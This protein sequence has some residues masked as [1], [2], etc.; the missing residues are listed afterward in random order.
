MKF[1][2]DA[3]IWNY[4]QVLPLLFVSLSFGSKETG[5]EAAAIEVKK[6]LEAVQE[7]KDC[8]DRFTF[9]KDTIINLFH[10]R[11]K[12]PNREVIC[13]AFLSEVLLAF[14]HATPCTDFFRSYINGNF[15]SDTEFEKEVLFMSQYMKT[16]E[17]QVYT[18]LR[19]HVCHQID[20]KKIEEM[21]PEMKE[22]PFKTLVLKEEFL[23]L[24]FMTQPIELTYLKKPTML[25]WGVRGIVLDPAQKLYYLMSRDGS[26]SIVDDDADLTERTSG[27][28]PIKLDSEGCS[29]SV[30]PTGAHILIVDFLDSRI[31]HYETAYLLNIQKNKQNMKEM[32]SA[33]Y[34]TLGNPWRT[35]WLNEKEFCTCSWTG[36]IQMFALGSV[37]SSRDINFFKQPI[38]AVCHIPGTNELI[39][40]DD[41]A[42]TFRVDLTEKLL[43]WAVT[44][45][46]LRI[47][48]ISIAPNGKIFAS[49]GRDSRVLLQKVENGEILGNFHTFSGFKWYI[50]LIKWSPC[51]RFLLVV[52]GINITILRRYEETNSYEEVSNMQTVLAKSKTELSNS[53]IIGDIEDTCLTC[54][55]NWDKSYVLYARGIGRV[56]KINLT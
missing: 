31:Y 6:W 26:Y 55:V 44:N 7:E 54:E 38:S 16:K 52:S 41:Q 28:F 1:Q 47:R 37:V 19:T 42:N 23:P 48:D 22:I 35:V 8:S 17:I 9:Q 46:K 21:V 34:K 50:T 36:F 25:C 45:H 20:M 27:K 33:C 15:N 10:T 43:V 51:Q 5:D 40:G 24:K 32:A 12:H 29:V 18:K 30:N 3:I 49:G 4:L 11:N 53:T 13:K 56:F 39:C 14:P 2:K